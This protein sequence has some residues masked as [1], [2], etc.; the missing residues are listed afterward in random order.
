MPTNE[1]P[2]STLNVLPRT[3]RLGDAIAIV[4]GSII[5]SGIFVKEG[6][7]AKEVGS[8]GP[9]L[10]VWLVVGIVTWCGALAIGELAAMMPRAGG[11]YVYLR[12]AY[13][14]LPAFLWGWTEFW[15]IRTGSI[16]SLACAAVL[17]LQELVRRSPTDPGL[18][19]WDQGF[20]AGAIL[21]LF[22]GINVRGTR[23]AATVQNVTTIVKVGF[24]AALIV[25]PWVL[26][27]VDFSNLEPWKPQSL[28]LSFWRNVGIAMIAV[29]WPYDG[30][31]SLGF[32]AEE[33]EKPQRN[34]PLAL[35]MGLALIVL[36]YVSATLSYHLVLPFDQVSG[37][38]RIAADASRAL[39]GPM[40]AK[41]A[42]GCVMI[43]AVGACNANMLTGP[44]IYFAV[45]RDG[46]LPQAVSRLHPKYRTPANAIWMQTAWAIVLLAGV[47]AWTNPPR[48]AEA[49]V[50]GIVSITGVRAAFDHLTDFVIFGGELF[51]AMTVAAVFVLRRRNP[52]A[53]R[54]YK[55]WGYPVTPLLYLT[56]FTAV[57]VSLIVAKPLESAVGSGLI[58]AG[59]FYYL[60]ASRQQK[61]AGL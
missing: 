13:G 21:L 60:W 52:D 40:G 26:A 41:I 53:E 57:L 47:F 55:T 34:V 39:F 31:V 58:V 3:L 51:Y 46:L 12:E 48:S 45:A 32:V 50:N 33:I 61:A 38:E 7:I 23:W 4:V 9:I 30:W 1:S 25:M 20:I 10:A 14:P 5:G 24:L 17:Y 28:D 19:H 6:T 2:A 29:K 11:P 36:I 35:S 27:K 59:V 56:A 8:F 16:G 22:A 49:P 42:A 54:P 43:S 37:A 18:G 15:I 44:R